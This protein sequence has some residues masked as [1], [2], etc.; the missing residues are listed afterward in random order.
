[1]F[2]SQALIQNRLKITPKNLQEQMC[3]L[4]RLIKLQILLKI[5]TLCV[6]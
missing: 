4:E 1:M 5:Y 2:K 6:I 3:L